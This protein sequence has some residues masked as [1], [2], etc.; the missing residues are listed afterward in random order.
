MEDDGGVGALLDEVLQ[1]LGAE[2][3]VAAEKRVGDDA[4]GPHVHGLAVAALQ[5]DLGGGVAEGAGHGGEDLVLAVE[6][7]G[8]AKV[9]EDQVGVVVLCQVEQVLGLEV[10]GVSGLVG[11][12]LR[13]GDRWGDAPLWT[14]LF[15]W[16]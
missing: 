11:A 9:G 1:R 5:H 8:D 6:H 14:T 3:R 4:Q 10:W 16:R 12:R 2:G 15:W 13:E 7:L